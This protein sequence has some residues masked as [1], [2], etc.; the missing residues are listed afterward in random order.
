[1][2]PA[3]GTW[4]VRFRVSKGGYIRALARDLGEQAGCGAHLTALRRVASGALSVEDAVDLARVE[5]AAGS[6]EE[7][8]TGAAP[9]GV[10]ALFADPVAALGMVCIEV[11]AN[12]IA[13]GRPIPVSA[14]GAGG[15]TIPEQGEA[16]GVLADGHFAGV[17]RRRR[18]KMVAEVVLAV[19]IGRVP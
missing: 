19:P 14:L 6:A 10:T 7:A 5:A 1:M 2:D 13:D 8:E 11:A 9:A 18:D 15:G 4:T 12:A 17:Y 16:L 3:A